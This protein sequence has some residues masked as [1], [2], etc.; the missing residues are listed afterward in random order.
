[1]LA[2]TNEET[3]KTYVLH[4]PQMRH[5]DASL[6]KTTLLARIGGTREWHCTVDALI[7]VDDCCSYYNFILAESSSL[8]APIADQ[9]G[10]WQAYT[11]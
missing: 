5:G 4:K 3:Q 8:Y 2:I 7:C 9:F 11:S 10:Y 6:E 1:M